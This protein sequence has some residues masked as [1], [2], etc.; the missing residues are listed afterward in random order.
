MY[1]SLCKNG[2]MDIS[3]RT[4]LKDPESDTIEEKALETF[5]VILEIS[6][7]KLVVYALQT[8]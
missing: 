5:N 2:L 6:L 4:T 1:S 8:V 3:V 7:N